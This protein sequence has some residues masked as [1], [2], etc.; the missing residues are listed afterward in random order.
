[1][2]HDDQIPAFITSFVQA[3]RIL[4]QHPDKSDEWLKGAY[5]LFRSFEILLREILSSAEIEVGGKGWTVSKLSQE[6]LSQANFFPNF[7]QELREIAEHR[8]MVAHG[9]PI[10]FAGDI[11]L[12]DLERIRRLA[13]WYLH[14]FSKGPRLSAKA[15]IELLRGENLI[16][17]KVVFIS[18]AREDQ[19]EANNL[20]NALRL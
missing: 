20:Y 17:P 12:E 16:L 15:S 14:D 9:V 1:M 6:V 13:V 18:Y 11:F 19:D 10:S 2:K 3:D 4:S 5:I 7:S 8:N